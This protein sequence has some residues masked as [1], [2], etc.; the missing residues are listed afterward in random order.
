MCIT[1]IIFI[2]F[3]MLRLCCIANLAP[4]MRPCVGTID[5][6]VYTDSMDA[7]PEEWWVMIMSGSR[8]RLTVCRACG[9]AASATELKHHM[10]PHLCAFEHQNW[11]HVVLSS[12]PLLKWHVTTRAVS[13]TQCREDSDPRNIDNA[14]MVALRGFSTK[15]SSVHCR[16]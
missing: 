12:T 15:V 9:L 3:D 1:G 13:K 8:Q 5:I 4:C 2:H 11:A 7:V 14:E 10:L 6:L 16:D